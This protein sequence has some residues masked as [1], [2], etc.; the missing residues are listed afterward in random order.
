MEK[1]IKISLL[2]FMI[3]VAGL[4]SISLIAC[5]SPSYSEED[6]TNFS[7][8]GLLFEKGPIFSGDGNNLDLSL[9][10]PGDI[11]LTRWWPVTFYGS[12][13]SH[14]M[15]YAGNSLVV[16]ATYSGILYTDIEIIH[17]YDA[18][19]VIRV[20]TT[21][22]IK[23]AAINFAKYQLG[24]AY[25]ILS[26][27]ISEYESTYYSSELVWAAYKIN[28]VDIDAYPGFAFPFGLNV[29]PDEIAN[30][31]NTFIVAYSE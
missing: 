17:E 18:C 6:E 26:E 21:R 28:D 15:L 29:A 24:K 12:Y 23:D 3:T 7:L 5:A 31:D 8:L 9:L 27:Y 19:I 4:V 10:E 22:A 30:D 20:D 2:I 25:D 14:A 16:E 13:W 11:I 1:N